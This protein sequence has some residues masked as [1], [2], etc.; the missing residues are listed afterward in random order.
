MSHRQPTS[1]SRSS[2][3]AAATA[4]SSTPRRRCSALRLAAAAFC[5]PASSAAPAALHVEGHRT[6]RGS[7][8][9]GQALRP[10]RQIQA[11]SSGSEEGVR[12]HM[13]QGAGDKKL[14]STEGQQQ[15]SDRRGGTGVP[16]LLHALLHCRHLSLGVPQ[17]LRHLQAG[18]AR[19]LS[20][21]PARAG[22]IAGCGDSKHLR[23][24]GAAPTVR[25]SNSRAS[26]A[27]RQRTLPRR[28]PQAASKAA[29]KLGWRG[30]GTDLPCLLLF[31]LS[32]LPSLLFLLLQ[33]NHP[34]GPR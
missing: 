14:G 24:A 3:S 31:L 16:L 21:E 22:C 6:R 1:A 13:L 18:C 7:G 12:K 9:E 30:A 5:R 19:K 23:P 33:L 34:Q 8:V 20:S 2:P 25:S 10:H 11:T 26:A 32:L 28:D 27:W 29:P 17:L 15:C 4:L